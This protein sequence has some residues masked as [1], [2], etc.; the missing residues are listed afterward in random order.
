[1][2]N[3]R[4]TW[5]AK[6]H[7]HATPTP[8]HVAVPPLLPSPPHNYPR[9]EFVSVCGKFVEAA[10]PSR[11]ITTKRQLHLPLPFSTSL[12]PNVG[13]CLLRW[14]WRV[15]TACPQPLLLLNSPRSFHWKL[16]E[17]LKDSVLSFSIWFFVLERKEVVARLR[18]MGKQ[19]K[20]VQQGCGGKGGKLVENKMRNKEIKIK[21][22]V[23]YVNW[24][25]YSYFQ[26]HFEYIALNTFIIIYL[27]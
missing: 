13:T 22:N 14:L 17:M 2:C 5:S 21:V 10:L 6:A 24:L 20:G 4:P 25:F 16:R 19:L 12:P 27:H 23:T 8:S 1:M 18:L 9:A 3:W 11:T 26:L 15:L 7:F